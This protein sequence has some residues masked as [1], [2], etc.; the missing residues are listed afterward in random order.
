[1]HMDLTP[2]FT[3]SGEERLL[4]TESE[5]S[6]CNAYV[7]NYINDI[8]AKMVAISHTKSEKWGYV[9]RAVY[10]SNF[11]SEG[12]TIT[13]WIDINSGEMH[14]SVDDPGSEIDLS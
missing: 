7:A 5:L 6:L 14:V 9:V 13:C 2:P 4:G 12:G 3:V 10:S 8:S 11:G 1:M